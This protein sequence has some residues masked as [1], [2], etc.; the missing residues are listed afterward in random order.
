M[1]K[2]DEY[3]VII[4]TL[5]DAFQTISNEQRIGQLSLKRDYIPCVCIHNFCFLECLLCLNAMSL[6]YS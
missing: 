4:R 6:F 2:R 1:T 3:I 5:S